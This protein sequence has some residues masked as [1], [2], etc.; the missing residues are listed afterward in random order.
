MNGR[1]LFEK[2]REI[3]A[4]GFFGVCTTVVNLVV[5]WIMAHVLG[6]ATVPSTIIAW[7]V[8]VLFAYVT[9]RKW[10]FA[11]NKHAYLA[12][13]REIL[14]FFT[15]RLATGI[16]DWIIMYAFVDILHFNDIAIKFVVNLVV[17]IFNYI[18]SKLLIFKRDS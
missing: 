1:L 7:F 18:A 11:S 4:Y 14:S 3:L 17:I 8:S 15:C 16:L 12:I 13:F 5:Y 2:Y 6:L 10:V 9:N